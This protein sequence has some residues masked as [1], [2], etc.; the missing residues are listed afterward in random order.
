MSNSFLAEFDALAAGAFADAGMADAAQFRFDRNAALSNCTVY[1]DRGMQDVGDQAVRKNPLITITS[2][3]AEIP[4]PKIN[5]SEFVVGGE[6]FV[7]VAQADN[8][9]ESRTVNT[10]R[11][12]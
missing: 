7:V 10:V 11:P 9:D 4:V 12:K 5:E 8:S 6:T 3:R 2:F 1:V